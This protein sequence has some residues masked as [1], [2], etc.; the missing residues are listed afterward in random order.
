MSLP[1]ITL[2]ICDG[3]VRLIETDV[4]VKIIA[5]D[6]DVDG[7][8]YQDTKFDEDGDEYQEIDVN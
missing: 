3:A 8:F 6:Y 7:M 1:T 4:D 5:R 2:A